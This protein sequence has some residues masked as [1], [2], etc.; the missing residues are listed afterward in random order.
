MTIQ[1][2]LLIASVIVFILAALPVTLS[3]AILPVGLALF[4]ASF[5]S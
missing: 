3:F 2:A 1:K 5:I 4:A